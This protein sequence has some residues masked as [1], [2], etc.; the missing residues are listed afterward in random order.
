MEQ[1]ETGMN[2]L[3]L[4]SKNTEFFLFVLLNT[5][6]MSDLENYLETGHTDSDA[7]VVMYILSLTIFSTV[8]KTLRLTQREKYYGMLSH[9]IE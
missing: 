5:T 1:S 4:S 3:N 7:D 8:P 9:N 2:Y 6:Q